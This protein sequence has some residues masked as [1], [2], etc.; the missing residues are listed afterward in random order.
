MLVHNE[1]V[2]HQLFACQNGKY[3]KTSNTGSS[4]QAN[5]KEPY[6]IQQHKSKPQGSRLSLKPSTNAALFTQ[7]R[8]GNIAVLQEIC[9]FHDWTSK[10]PL[11]N[12]QELSED[13]AMEK[14]PQ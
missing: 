10:W 12:V 3:A 5:H 2:L 8:Y 11:S 13:A 14:N 4:I 9:A 6:E 7:N 1:A